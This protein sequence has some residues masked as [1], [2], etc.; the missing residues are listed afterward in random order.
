MCSC[1]QEGTRNLFIN[2][3]VIGKIEA[4]QKLNTKDKFIGVD[5]STWYQ[6]V[7]RKYRGDSRENSISKINKIIEETKK[8]TD[9]A[10]KDIH[11]NEKC[12][13]LLNLTPLDFLKVLVEI[14][15]NT[16]NGLNNLRNTYNYDTKTSSQLEMNIIVIR[17]CIQ[18]I[19]QNSQKQKLIINKLN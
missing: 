4:E 16:L 5:D 8:I 6:W 12:T 14:L 7:I 1:S 3:K 11:K 18:E 13:H 15:K 2:L 10:F 19:E 9:N 17:K